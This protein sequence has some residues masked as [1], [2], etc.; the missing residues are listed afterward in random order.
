M[1]SRSNLWTIGIHKILDSSPVNTY[2]FMI[3]FFMILIYK[4]IFLKASKIR[5]SKYSV[6]RELEMDI[7]WRVEKVTK[8]QFEEGK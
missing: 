5:K 6:E 8:P 1:I 7:I 2:A 3:I 4:L